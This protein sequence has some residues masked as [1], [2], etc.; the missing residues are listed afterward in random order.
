MAV[1][2]GGLIQTRNPSKAATKGTPLI[3]PAKSPL[4][5]LKSSKMCFFRGRGR[6]GFIGSGVMSVWLEFEGRIISD[7]DTVDGQNPLRT[8]WDG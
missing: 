4:L 6:Y 3:P 2:Y 5:I 7:K 1:E 8:F